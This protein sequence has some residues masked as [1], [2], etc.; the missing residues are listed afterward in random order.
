MSEGPPQI[1][2]RLLAPLF[3]AATVVFFG[4]GVAI[5]VLHGH[6]L[7]IARDLHGPASVIWL[8][9]LGIHVM[10][11]LGRALRTTAEE[12]RSRLRGAAARGAA[13]ELVRANPL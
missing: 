5:G 3:V 8:V 2:M 10:V 9:L 13:P 4:S 1:A 6:A 7:R 12:K 11:H